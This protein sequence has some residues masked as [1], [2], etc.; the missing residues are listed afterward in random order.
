[1]SLLNLGLHEDRKKWTTSIS[2]TSS[3]VDQFCQFQ[4]LV[5]SLFLQKFKIQKVDHISN[6]TALAGYIDGQFCRF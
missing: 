4:I 3:Y 2:W 1:M 5:Q 6:L